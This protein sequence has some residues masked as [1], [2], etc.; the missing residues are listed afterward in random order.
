MNKSPIETIV[1]ST[2]DIEDAYRRMLYFYT[3]DDYLLEHEG[4][5]LK[6]EPFDIKVTFEITGKVKKIGGE[7][8]DN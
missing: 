4:K 1:I 7:C 8:S 3:F 5:I 6:I 2:D